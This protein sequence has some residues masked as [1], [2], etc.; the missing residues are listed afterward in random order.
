[1]TAR[2][3]LVVLLALGAVAVN[4]AT[5]TERS[6]EV[7]LSDSG[8]REQIRIRVSIEEVGDLDAWSEY[9]ILVDEN[10]ELLSFSIEIVDSQGDRVDSLKKRHLREETSVGFGL[11][12]SS[13]AMVADLPT[14]SVGD[15]ISISYVRMFEPLFLADWAPILLDVPQSSLNIRISGSSESL[16]WSLRNAEE[17][18]DVVDTGN[19]IHCRGQDLPRREPP[20][21][22]GDVLSVGPALVWTWD[23]A[24]TWNEVGA[25]YA[26]L[27]DDVSSSSVQSR[28]LVDTVTKD[29]G[30]AREKVLALADYA[31]LK[32]RYEAVEIG[33]GGWVPTP[34][35]EVLTRGWGDCKDKSELLKALLAGIGVKAHLVLIHNGR[36][37]MIDPNFP[38]TLGFNH[39]ILAVETDGFEILPTDPVVDGLLFLDPTLD[40]GA[41]EWLNP[42]IQGQW[43]LVAAGETGRLVRLP[44]RYAEESRAMRLEGVIDEGGA[45]RGTARVMMTGLRA[46]GWLRDLDSEAPERI[47]E[48]ARRYLQ[49][50]LPGMTLGTLAWREIEGTV[51]TFAVEGIVTCDRFVRSGRSRRLRFSYLNTLPET[52]ELEGRNEPMVI[53][54]GIN[55]TQWRLILPE[56]WCPPAAQPERVGNS[57]GSIEQTVEIDEAGRLVLTRK[58]VVRRSWIGVESFEHLR[59]LAGAENRLSRGSLRMICPESE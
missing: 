43:A 48:A 39:C 57:I 51:P 20:D 59:E 21:G 46:V 47:E 40:R 4:A 52:R 10:I 18:V 33:V 55:L 2:S 53:M 23:P 15:R 12:S 13:S 45:F 9:S 24:G 29:L 25:W 19:G 35:H 17:L 8:M 36:T 50:V 41:A 56:G 7:Q 14:L 16:R 6:I 3:C 1:M 28:R 5:I 31:R 30:S 22:A 54:P 42:T 49:Y 37:A 34:A 32:V 11:H 26:G 27:T 44:V 38:S 58:T